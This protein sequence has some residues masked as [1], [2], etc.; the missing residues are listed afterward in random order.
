M[1]GKGGK[2]K[3]K[4]NPNTALSALLKGINSAKRRK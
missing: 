3:H 2:R 4:Q 1:S